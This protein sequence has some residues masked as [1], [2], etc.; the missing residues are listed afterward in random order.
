MFKAA[1]VTAFSTA[2][3][4]EEREPIGE[5]LQAIGKPAYGLLIELAGDVGKKE[6]LR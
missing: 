2:K 1:L 6:D 5:S 4:Q 3:E